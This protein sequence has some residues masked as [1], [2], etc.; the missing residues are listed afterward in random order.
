VR[1]PACRRYFCRECV[2]EHDERLL[3]AACLER[4]ANSGARKQG[5]LAGT[6]RA[7]AAALGLMLAWLVFYGIGQF[8][9]RIPAQMDQGTAWQRR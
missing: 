8:L 5:R 9:A 7:L 3:C 1:C 4:L 2:T 6:R